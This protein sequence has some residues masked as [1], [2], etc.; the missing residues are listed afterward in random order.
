MAKTPAPAAA[1]AAAIDAVLDTLA[2]SVANDGAAAAAAAAV[3]TP[4]AAP[5]GLTFKAVKVL[6]LPL[7]KFTQDVPAYLRFDDK[8]FTGKTIVEL[9]AT[10][11]DVSKA[12]PEMVNCTDMQTG[13][14]C[15]IMLGKV[16]L[17]LVHETYPDSAYVGRVFM[18]T[19]GAKKKGRGAGQYNTY[20]I[21]EV[22]VE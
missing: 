12:P 8:I 15:Q 19:Q 5:K 6:T 16:L 13:A 10:G 18:I 11:K 1:A 4:P 22:E 21:T 14:Q 9:D 3:N 7:F 20:S 17:G 2:Q